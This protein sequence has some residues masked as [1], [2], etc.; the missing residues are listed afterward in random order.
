MRK[1]EAFEVLQGRS[2]GFVTRFFAF[3]VDLVVVVGILAVGG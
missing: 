2:A 1:N 3:V